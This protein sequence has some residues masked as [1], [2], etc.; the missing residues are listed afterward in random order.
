MFYDY[1]IFWESFTA[2]A[3]YKRALESL[4][5]KCFFIRL[6]LM[7]RIRSGWSLSSFIIVG[8]SKIEIPPDAAELADG[9]EEGSLDLVEVV[10]HAVRGD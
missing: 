6:T 5:L 9:S 10:A 4:Q 1:T 2:D 3:A 8:C 7:T